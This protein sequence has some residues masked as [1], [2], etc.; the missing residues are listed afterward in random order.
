M[1]VDGMTADGLY[2][3][4]KYADLKD[5]Y[6][7]GAVPVE[8]DVEASMQKLHEDYVEAFERAE[9]YE[10]AYK[11]LNEHYKKNVINVTSRRYD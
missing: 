5:A 9:H 8:P 11:H 7:S 2:W 4:N 1:Y 6:I 3:M 10:R